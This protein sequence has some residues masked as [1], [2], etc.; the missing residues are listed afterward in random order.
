MKSKLLALFIMILLWPVAL[1]SIGS[2][3]DADAPVVY[4]AEQIY[5]RSYAALFYIRVLQSDGTV[6]S[7]GTGVTV[8][9]DGT[10]VTACHVVKQAARIE[11]TFPDGRTVGPIEVLSFDEAT[12]VAIVKLPDPVDSNGQSKP[13]ETLAIR[14]TAVKHGEK[15]FALGYPI[16]NT[17]IITE[18]IVNTP[19]AEINGRD[20]IL[21]SAQIASGMS[22]GPLLDQQGRLSGIISG[23]MR[24]MNNIH[25]VIDMKDVRSLLQSAFS[26]VQH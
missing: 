16:K 17:P 8:S 22:G 3:A 11:G 7:A 6:A 18:G 10:A 24:T 20:R 2:H 15:V 4:N 19:K 9:P 25:L 1:S 14:E 23:S 26:A 13:Y 12:D 21:T 5:G